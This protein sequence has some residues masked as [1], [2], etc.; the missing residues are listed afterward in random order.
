MITIYLKN[1]DLNEAEKVKAVPYRNIIVESTMIDWY[2]KVGR[3]SDALD[4]MTEK[5]CVLL[6]E[7]DFWVF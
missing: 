5:K 1:K 7:F 4:N 3:L 6:N 2:V